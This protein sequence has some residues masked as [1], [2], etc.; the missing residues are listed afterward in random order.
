MDISMWS[1]PE[2]ISRS[3][4][5]IQTCFM[6]LITILSSSSRRRAQGL[7]LGARST[8]VQQS[9]LEQHLV[10]GDGG[11]A[12][13]S[14]GLHTRFLSIAVHGVECGSTDQNTSTPICIHGC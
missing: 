3:S 7:R 12:R 8:S 9:P 11:L 14:H 2:G 13:D 10:A 6:C 5:S 4:L 1:R